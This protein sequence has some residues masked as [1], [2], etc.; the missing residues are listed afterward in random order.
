MKNILVIGKFY[1]D[2]FAN[3][4][5]ETFNLMNYNTTKYEISKNEQILFFKQIKV[6]YR[7]YLFLNLI[8][9]I[10]NSIKIFRK[11]K[12]KKLL[13]FI[14]FNKNLDLIVFTYDFMWPSEIAEIK[15]I[16]KSKVVMW[17][18]DALSTF[19]KGYF[20]N[21]DYDFLFFKDPYIVKL[22][23]GVLKSDV[24]YLPE[25]F[26]PQKHRVET[27]KFESSLYKCDITSAGNQHSWRNI[28]FE[29]LKDYDVKFWGLEPPIWMPKGVLF[30]YFQGKPVYNSEKAEAFI[31]AKIVLNNLH[32]SEIEGLN[33]RCFEAAGI[34]AFQIVDWR[35]GLSDL[36]IDGE[37]IVSFKSIDDL[38]NKLNYYLLNDKE[39]NR[40]ANNGKNR[41]YKD[42]TYFKRLETMINIIFK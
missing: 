32:Y 41:A 30:S 39:R 29:H 14:S 31:N 37:E 12:L 4:I 1:N 40:I 5:F 35:P 22:F 27:G 19:G 16:T 21:A 18:P 33:V 6:F 17:Y 42:H 24:Y 25:C 20:I 34:G 26:N 11:S 15:S 36:F 28:I 2:S 10:L 13:K 3:H 7:A 38:K 9:G 23:S 8:L